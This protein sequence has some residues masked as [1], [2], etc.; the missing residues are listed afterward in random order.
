[1]L[2]HILFKSGSYTIKTASILAFN[3]WPN[4]LPFWCLSNPDIF[5]QN[6]FF[7]RESGNYF[8]LRLNMAL[9]YSF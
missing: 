4:S 6:I 1:M 8:V 2:T 5:L 3:D 9:I 7:I